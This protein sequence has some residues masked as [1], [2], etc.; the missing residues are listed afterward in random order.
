MVP[1]GGFVL[2]QAAVQ[3]S[4]ISFQTNCELNTTPMLLTFETYYSV[5]IRNKQILKGGMTYV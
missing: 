3:Y 2:N 4:V 5:S 1:P